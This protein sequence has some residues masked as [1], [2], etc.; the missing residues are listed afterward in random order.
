EDIG[1]IPRGESPP[2]E[3][4]SFPATVVDSEFGGR[5]MDVSIETG[6]TRLQARIPAGERGGWARS[7][8][9][10][11]QVVA[12]VRPAN[13]VF[14]DEAGALVTRTRRAAA[15]AGCPWRPRPSRSHVAAGASGSAAWHPASG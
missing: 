1:L 4:V 7:L 5:Y 8:N 13:L 11:Q 15:V 10:G 6:L 9:A 2:P 3:T 14:Y 12:T